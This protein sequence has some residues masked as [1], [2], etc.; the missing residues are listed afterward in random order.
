MA[1]ISDLT[2]KQLED[3]AR[4]R[5]EHWKRIGDRLRNKRIRTSDPIGSI[6]SAM[7]SQPSPDDIVN[8]E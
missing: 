3:L 8:E 5:Q 4:K 1:T 7:G 6:R 2:D